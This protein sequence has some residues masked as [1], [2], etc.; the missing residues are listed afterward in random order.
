MAPQLKLPRVLDPQDV[1]STSEIHYHNHLHHISP[2]WGAA[3][4]DIWIV[5]TSNTQQKYDFEVDG[6]YDCG[7]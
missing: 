1:S 3:G 6:V 4:I 2:R 7:A 5:A